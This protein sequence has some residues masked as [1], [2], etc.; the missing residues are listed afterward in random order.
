M[1]TIRRSTGKG[2]EIF[3]RD[4][5]ADIL[6][7]ADANL[8]LHFDTPTRRPIK[9][10]SEILSPNELAALSRAVL[11][12]ERRLRP[13]SGLMEI[14]RDLIIALSDGAF[15]SFT[16]SFPKAGKRLIALRSFEDR[17]FRFSGG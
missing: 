16:M 15:V 5:V 13:P 7:R 1:P 12:H 6:L 2:L 11:D 3:N 9:T 8:W 4:A 17:P 14:E 10:L